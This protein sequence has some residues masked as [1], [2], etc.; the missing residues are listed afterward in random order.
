MDATSREPELSSTIVDYRFCSRTRPRLWANTLTADT[1]NNKPVGNSEQ[2][3]L[4]FELL[5]NPHL[6]SARGTEASASITRPIET[7]RSRAFEKAQARVR[8]RISLSRSRR[9]ASTRAR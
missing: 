6:S 2:L 7:R 8:A 9:A 3:F 4:R 5:R 1:C